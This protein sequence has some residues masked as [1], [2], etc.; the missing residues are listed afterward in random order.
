MN[1]KNNKLNRFTTF[2]ILLDMFR[3]KRL[4][5]SD[6]K[7]WED[8]NDLKL[9]EILPADNFIMQRQRP[10]SLPLVLR[11]RHTCWLIRQEF[12]FSPQTN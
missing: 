12:S 5:F 1:S 8:E 3:R 2:P 7:Y 9:L 10:L 11:G 6:P 4:V